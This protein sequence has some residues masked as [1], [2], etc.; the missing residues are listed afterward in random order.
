MI[1]LGDI[2]KKTEEAVDKTKDVTKE[3]GGEV[4]KTGEKAKDA[5]TK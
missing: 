4:K 5:V 1:G 2:K 3:A